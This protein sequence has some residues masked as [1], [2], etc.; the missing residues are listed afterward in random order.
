MGVVFAQHVAHAGGGLLEGLVVGQAA[1]IH[2][3]EDPAVDGLQA[4]P[5][6]RQGP[7]HDD[8]HG[9]LDIGL[10]HLRHQGGDFD[11]LV[12]VPDL[13]RV[14]LGFFTHKL[15]FLTLS[16]GIEHFLIIFPRTRASEKYIDL[17]AQGGVTSAHTGEGETAE[18]PPVADEARLFRG[19]GAIS[20]PSR[21]GNRNAA[22]VDKGGTQS[23]L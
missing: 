10:L 8:G 2:G 4:V 6:V 1:L 14:V 11:L 7:A 17:A 22:T 13:L 23:P 3:V 15:S 12:R 18:A 20:G 19:S 5:H 21:A 9:V 16:R